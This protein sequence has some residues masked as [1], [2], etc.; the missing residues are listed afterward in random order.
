[1]ITTLKNENKRQPNKQK[2]PTQ[3]TFKIKVYKAYAFT[4]AAEG[5]KQQQ[6]LN[7]QTSSMFS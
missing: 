5:N 2:T 6:Q 7:Y 3:N 1:M 4:K